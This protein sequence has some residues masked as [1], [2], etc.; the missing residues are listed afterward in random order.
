M[1]KF[2]EAPA[3]LSS[4]QEVRK[5]LENDDERNKIGTV[6]SYKPIISCVKLP[7]ICPKLAATTSRQ[8]NGHAYHKNRS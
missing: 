7:L 1:M 5:S 6:Y 3:K 8:N 2:T 4:P